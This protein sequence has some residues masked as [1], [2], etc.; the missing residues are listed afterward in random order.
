MFQVSCFHYIIQV[1]KMCNLC[2]FLYLYCISCIDMGK[3]LCSAKLLSEI[4]K[5]KHQFHTLFSPIPFL[6]FTH[7]PFPTPAAFAHNSGRGGG[8]PLTNEI[9]FKVAIRYL[10]FKQIRHKSQR[11]N[12]LLYDC[13]NKIA[14]PGL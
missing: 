6:N 8:L 13:H 5:K 11:I 2:P 14:V 4:K 1:L 12:K 10:C 7:P 9:S 3:N